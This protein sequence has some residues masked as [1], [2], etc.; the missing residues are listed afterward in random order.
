MIKQTIEV[1]C[2]DEE[3]NATIIETATTHDKHDHDH[4]CWKFCA[5]C[6]SAWY[7]LEERYIQHMPTCK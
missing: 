5:K 7:N 1:D 6:Q 4:D 3:S 2:S